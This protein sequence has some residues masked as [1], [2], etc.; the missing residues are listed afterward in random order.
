MKNHLHT[1][2]ILY[3]KGHLPSVDVIFVVIK[4]EVEIVHTSLYL[5]LLL[6]GIRMFIE[7][8]ST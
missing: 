6:M 1:K 3:F 8:T 5:V 2:K 7:Y 4:S